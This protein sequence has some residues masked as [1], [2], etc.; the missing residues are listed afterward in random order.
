MKLY[1]QNIPRKVAKGCVTR[2]TGTKVNTIGVDNENWH[3]SELH[4]AK[5]NKDEKFVGKRWYE[6]VKEK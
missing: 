2:S 5:G 1:L 4:S 3:G 6:F